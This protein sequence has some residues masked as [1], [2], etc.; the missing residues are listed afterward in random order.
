MSVIDQS[1]DL[2]QTITAPD[3]KFER[4]LHQIRDPRQ[5]ATELGAF[6][7]ERL[8]AKPKSGV[9]RLGDLVDVFRRAGQL[10]LDVLKLG[11]HAPVFFKEAPALPDHGS[12]DRVSVHA[13][14]I[15]Y[16]INPGNV[17]QA[18]DGKTGELIWE[19]WTGPANRQEAG[20]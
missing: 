11:N 9:H 3:L 19:H 12:K 16:L 6:L 18:L 8:P 13:N 17:I 20:K 10:K 5:L 14:G 7:E 15:V 1:F 2:P 4:D